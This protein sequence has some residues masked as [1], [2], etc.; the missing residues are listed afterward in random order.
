MEEF[1]LNE[2]DLLILEKLKENSRLSVLQL[3]RKTGI[4]PTTIHNRIKRLREHKVITNYTIR[5]DREKTG[6]G[7]CAL[8]FVY[9]NNSA[10]P[11]R[12]KKGGLAKHIY[13]FSQVSQ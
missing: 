4:P 13:S 11:Q 9:L 3:S 8:V 6:Q 1:K 10:L 12:F 7:F 5:V 2:K